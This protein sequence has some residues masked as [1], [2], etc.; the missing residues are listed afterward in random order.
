M[1][2]WR[3]ELVNAALLRCYQPHQPNSFLTYFGLPRAPQHH[4]AVHFD[5]D[6]GRYSQKDEQQQPP[7]KRRHQLYCHL[8]AANETIGMH[9]FIKVERTGS[10]SKERCSWSKSELAI[11]PTCLFPRAEVRATMPSE[12]RFLLASFRRLLSKYLPRRFLS[13]FAR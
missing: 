6:G 12:T 5:R 13:L 10:R 2:S 11:R 3:A 4:L 7:A 8:P 1:S 9:G